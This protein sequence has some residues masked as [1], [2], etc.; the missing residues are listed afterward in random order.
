MITLLSTQSC[1]GHIVVVGPDNASTGHA[2]ARP[3]N[4]VSK[5]TSP[6]F[7]RLQGQ[8]LCG[9]SVLLLPISS[10]LP[11]IQGMTSTQPP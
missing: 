6:L 5:P 1:S 10:R 8:E 4:P 7:G 9:N 11:S 3:V 2:R